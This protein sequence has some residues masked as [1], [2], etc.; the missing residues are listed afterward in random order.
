MNEDQLFYVLRQAQRLQR[1]C[2]ACEDSAVTKQQNIDQLW[3]HF[4][5][6]EDLLSQCLSNETILI[7]P[8][9][10][11]SIGIPDKEIKELNDA[12][13]PLLVFVDL[14]IN[15]SLS[16][17]RVYEFLAPLMQKH[18]V[19]IVTDINGADLQWDPFGGW[20][21][22][23]PASVGAIP[24]VSTFHGATGWFV[25]PDLEY[26]DKTQ[27]LLQQSFVLQQ[28]FLWRTAM[29]RVT[30]FVV[31]S[32]FA[33]RELQQSLGMTPDK[34][35]VIHHGV[36]H[37][38]YCP[39][40]DSYQ[41]VGFLHVAAQWRVIKNLDRII[42]AHAASGVSDPLTIIVYDW[43]PVDLP[44]WVRHIRGPL[45][46]VELAKYYRGAKALVFATLKETFGMP[47]A[48]AMACGCPVVTSYGS[49]LEELYC[50]AAVL[51]DPF[52][53]D[54]IAQGFIRV[55]EPRVAKR[56][57]AIGLIRANSYNWEVAAASYVRLFR[58]SIA[59]GPQRGLKYPKADE[60]SLL[61]R[62]WRRIL[63]I[64]HLAEK[65]KNLNHE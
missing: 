3:G 63:S 44:K 64:H 12:S 36:N 23:P 7:N 34:V 50:D 35:S 9:D 1:L 51:V 5:C 40:G 62:I 2:D 37:N 61:Q 41:D 54:S 52:N 38:I 57:R 30:R 27:A 10:G 31:P 14:S 8:V 33:G 16:M 46:P 11:Q 48:E 45:D 29:N 20:T 59:E 58:T 18:G 4:G 13:L 28:F 56:M 43:E 53:V 55:S 15:P 22:N 17:R 6:Y 42:A 32:F 47:V 24:Y 49:A 21:F 65:R 26:A 60:Q 19:Q 25:D 39:D